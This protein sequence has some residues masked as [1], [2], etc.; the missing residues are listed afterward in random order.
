MS[1]LHNI[2]TDRDASIIVAPQPATFG[3]QLAIGTAPVNLLDNPSGAANVPLVAR[4]FAEAKSLL[5]YSTDVANYGLMQTVIS[6]FMKFAVAPIVF[7]NVLDPEKAAHKTA[8]TG[9]AFTLTGGKT[10]IS[11]AGILLGSVVVKYGE[12]FANTATVDEDYVLSFDYDGYVDIAATSDGALAGVTSVQI[13][14]SKLN[15]AGVTEADIIGGISASGVRTG[16]ELADEVYSRYGIIPSIV[17]APG[18]SHIPAVAAALE[19]KVELMGDLVSGIAVVDL[20]AGN[21]TSYNTVQAAKETLGVSSRWVTVCYPNVLVGSKVF[22]MSAIVAALMQYLCASGDNIPSSSPDNKDIP[23]DG[24]CFSDG[25][26]VFWTQKQINDY[27]NK[28]GVVSAIQLNGW[29]AWGNNTSAYPD[30]TNPNDRFIKCV[31]IANYL[32]NRFKTEYLPSI[33]RNGSTKEMDSIVTNYNADLNALVPDHLA[34]AYI[35]FN[36]EDNPMSEILEG[37]WHFHTYYADWIPTEYIEND[38][39]WDSSILENALTTTEG[40]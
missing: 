37:R 9:T 35:V 21:T 20:P 26:E 22:C 18:F 12:D 1:Y 5:G 16:I 4:S 19:A 13:A 23:I 29:K 38:F 7:I 30:N 40:E 2:V 24:T 14:Y 39:T 32:E 36:K 3:V 11:V 15:P 31:T 6:S 25:T 8:V 28:Y 27:I 34:G 33:G 10:K 17:T